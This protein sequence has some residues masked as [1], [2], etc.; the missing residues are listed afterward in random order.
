MYK[1]FE[2][3][4]ESVAKQDNMLS[5]NRSAMERKPES[6]L[7]YE[8]EP[9]VVLDVILDDTHPAFKNKTL[10][11]DDYP[12]NADGSKPT[13]D[14]PNYSWIGRAKVRMVYSQNGVDKEL[15]AWAA[16]LENTGV[17]ELPLVNE[18]VIVV[19][20][21]N[22]YF[23]TRKLNIKSLINANADFNLER[24]YGLVKGNTEEG[25]TDLF[26]GPISEMSAKK[27]EEINTGALGRYFKFNSKIRAIKRFEGDTVIESRFGSSIRFGAYDSNRDNDSGLNDYSDG[28]G[29]PMVLIRNRQKSVETETEN[30]VKFNK[31]YILE[32]INKDG[33]SIQITSGKTIT[34][35]V[36][37]I[38]KTILQSDNLDEQSNFLPP[39]ETEF[40][41][42]ELSGDQI[43][44][45]SDRLIFSSKAGETIH[46]SKRRFSIV[47]DDEY[48]M[49][50]KKQ[51]VATVGGDYR[52]DVAGRAILTSNVS[53]TINSPQIFLGEYDEK[54]EPVLL[55][56]T[57]VL[58]LYTLCNW[59]IN[60]TDIQ[61]G[62]AKCQ[63]SHIH[64]DSL[65]K[66]GTPTPDWTSQI[67]KY[68]DSLTQTRKQLEE[69]RDSLPHLMSNRVFTTGGGG[70]PGHD[71]K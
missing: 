29:N 25:T 28:G 12:V 22:S 6:T 61:I 47:T 33:S 46:Y 56:R 43:V 14:D 37:T 7:F 27:I 4:N 60:Q 17:S 57:S 53:T 48:T 50:V 45:N 59:M 10:D 16:P 58:W 5:S 64:F 3:R 55:G 42:P 20:Y 70:A 69:L 38:E 65:G 44:I 39:K 40:K 1:V 35:F 11:A 67:S 23:Y 54:N 51:M 8:F 36:P 21:F 52:T 63:Q 9:A 24:V 71:G 15:L 34:Q 49:D 26:K 13:F 30:S 62:L 41:I 68:I 32:D 66:T 19:K 18:V 2:R 31:G